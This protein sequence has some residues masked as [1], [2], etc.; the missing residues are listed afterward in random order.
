MVPSFPP[1]DITGLSA[2]AAAQVMSIDA[3]ARTMAAE[4]IR[5]S[6]TPAEL[7]ARAEGFSPASEWLIAVNKDKARLLEL[8]ARLLALQSLQAHDQNYD[9]HRLHMALGVYEQLVLEAHGLAET[10]PCARLARAG[11]SPFLQALRAA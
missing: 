7:R 2:N 9:G 4:I 3:V 10:H 6:P 11:L 8:D 5:T 1:I